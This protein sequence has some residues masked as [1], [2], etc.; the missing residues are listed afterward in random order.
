MYD[1]IQTAEAL[2]D[3][4]PIVGVP[5]YLYH[6]NMVLSCPLPEEQNTR[7]RRIYPPEESAIGFGILTLKEIPKVTNLLDTRHSL[8]IIS[9]YT[10]KERF[11]SGM[12]NANYIFFIQ[13]CPFPIYTRSGEVH[14]QL[15]LSKQTVIL[16]EVQIERVA[17][18]LNYTFTNVLRLQKYLMLFNPNAS[19]NSYIIVPVKIGEYIYFY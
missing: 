13:L 12:F 18:F 9:H 1:F 5:S 3:C 16:D 8:F 4:R 2:T 10:F 6:I 14:V 7:G 17:T 11:S 19:E 15:K